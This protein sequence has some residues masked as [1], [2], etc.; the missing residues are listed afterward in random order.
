MENILRHAHSGLRWLVLAILL[1]AI[2]NAFMKKKKGGYTNQDKLVSI[3]SISFTHTQVVLGL[4][5]YFITGAYKGF[6]EMS[7]A[8]LRLHALEHPLTMIIGAVLITVGHIK[9]KKATE[10]TKKFG[11]TA[12][13]FSIGLLLILARI[14]W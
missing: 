6:S 8:T 5:L 13:F 11:A 1:Y 7:N 2:V 4:I 10:D 12:L 3:L 14:P 9:A